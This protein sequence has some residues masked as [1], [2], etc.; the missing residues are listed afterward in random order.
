M[1]MAQVTGQLVGK[2]G[3]R[4]LYSYAAVASPG[5]P[6]LPV[7]IAWLSHWQT[8]TVTDYQRACHAVMAAYNGGQ[9]HQLMHEHGVPLFMWN[10]G[11]CECADC[12]IVTAAVSVAPM[13]VVVQAD[14]GKVGIRLHDT[15]RTAAAYQNELVCGRR[16]PAAAHYAAE[17]KQD[18]FYT[19][20]SDVTG[21]LPT[22][23]S[24]EALRPLDTHPV[25]DTMQVA[26]V[27]AR[28]SMRRHELM[29]ACARALEREAPRSDPSMALYDMCELLQCCR[30]AQH[31]T[32]GY[33]MTCDPQPDENGVIQVVITNRRCYWEDDNGEPMLMPWDLGGDCNL[34]KDEDDKD[35]EE[36]DEDDDGSM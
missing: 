17:I 21:L 4:T 31:R 15:V 22:T 27:S 25:T 14:T 26:V 18:C 20:D 32:W 12:S 8:F 34:A 5:G 3:D 6:A 36:E 1:S 13:Q 24:R 9:L 7:H 11:G 35:N 30:C 33:D 19:Y 29:H 28:A 23:T 2:S 10:S 16:H